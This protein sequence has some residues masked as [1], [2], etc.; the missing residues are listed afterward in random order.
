M[1]LK[2]GLGLKAEQEME[3]RGDVMLQRIEAKERLK[4]VYDKISKCLRDK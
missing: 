1:W 4:E 3:C 2:I